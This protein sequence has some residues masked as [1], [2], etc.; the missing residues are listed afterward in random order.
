M[1]AFCVALLDW[2]EAVLKPFLLR[3]PASLAHRLGIGLR[4]SPQVASSMPSIRIHHSHSLPLDQARKAVERIAAHIAEQ[5]S[6]ATRWER[7][8]LHFQRTG[9]NG[10]ISL[11]GKDVAVAADL[12]FLLSPIKGRVESEIRRYL[13]EELA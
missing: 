8:V 11:D 12:S 4:R 7:N 10:T 9:V 5:F 6:V 1:D 13:D 3:S 2:I